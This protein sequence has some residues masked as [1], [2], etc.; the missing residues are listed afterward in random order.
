MSITA[1]LAATLVIASLS[2]AQSMNLG[3]QLLMAP[4]GATAVLLFAAPQSPFSKPFNVIGGHLLTA[5]IGLVCANY[6]DIG[7]W[8]LGLATGLAITLMILTD[9]LHPPAGANPILIIQTQQSWGFLL[10]P[11]LLG[12]VGLVLSARVFEKLKVF[13]TQNKRPECANSQQKKICQ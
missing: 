7:L 3:W 8:G 2:V 10:D 12:A 9:T 5:I 1:G 13:F 11:V 4:F 6:L